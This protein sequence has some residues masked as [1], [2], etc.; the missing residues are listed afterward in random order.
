[1]P[2]RETS[3]TMASA[4][5]SVARSSQPAG[6]VTAWPWALLGASQWNMPA[7]LASAAIGGAWLVPD[8]AAVGARP[9]RRA[10]RMRL[11]ERGDS[12]GRS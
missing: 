11:A 5:T 7:M 1:M 4:R 6:S 12:A 2:V 9:P 3:K 8:E 10:S